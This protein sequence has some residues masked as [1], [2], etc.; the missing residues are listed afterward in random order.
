MD[1]LIKAFIGFFFL[2]L[3]TFAGIGITSAAIDV[4]NAE[5]FAADAA[6][7]I[8]SSD[9]SPVVIS[10][11]K[12]KAKSINYELEVIEDDL[13]NDNVTDMAEI[14]VRYDYSINVINVISRKHQ[15]KS[16]AR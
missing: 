9:F 11:L 12:D 5:E 7:I 14:I 10:K 15:A 3:Q 2:L 6:Q 8:E 4:S 16:Y 13:D 1:Q